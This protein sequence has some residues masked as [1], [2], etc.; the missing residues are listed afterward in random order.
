M[1]FMTGIIYC[2]TIEEYVDERVQQMILGKHEGYQ[3]KLVPN[4]ISLTKKT[5]KR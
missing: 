5:K 1:I 3:I 4:W 2:K